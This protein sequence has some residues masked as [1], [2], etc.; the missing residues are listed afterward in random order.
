M[1]TI[2][3]TRAEYKAKYGVDAPGSSPATT[4]SEI[5]ATPS[6]KVVKMSRAE[7]QNKYGVAAPVAPVAPQE[8]SMIGGMVKSLV[9]APATMIARP[10]QAVQSAWQLAGMDIKGNE[11]K[12]KELNDEAYRLAFSLRTAR[13][14]DKP[15]I[16]TRV[17]EIQNQVSEISRKLGEGANWKPSAGGIIAEAPENWGDVKKDVGRGIQTVALGLTAPG[18]ILASGAAFGVGSSLEQGND[19]FSWD[20]AAS[21]L[22][23]MGFAKSID[24]WGKPVI[25]YVGGKLAGFAP[26][27]LKEIAAKGEGAVLDFMAKNKLLGGVAAPLSEKITAGAQA[28]D[29][30]INKG[31]SSMWQGAKNIR[32]S[33]YPNLS[34]K[35]R[36]QH[37]EQTETDKLIAP[38]R[39]NHKSF[40]SSTD[41]LNESKRRGIDLEQRV[42]DTKIYDDVVIDD[43][44][45]FDTL[46]AQA[47]LLD[48]TLSHIDK[49]LMHVFEAVEP[50][51]PLVRSNEVLQA[52]LN[53]ANSSDMLPEDKANFIKKL[54]LRYGPDSAEAAAYRQG[55]KLRDL[56]KS[57]TARTKGVYKKP[58]AGGET[59]ISD[60][61]SI[62]EKELESKAFND[63]L[64]QRTPEG[65]RLDDYFKAQESN[66]Q[67][68]EYLKTLHSKMAPKGKFAKAMGIAGQV[69]GGLLGLKMGGPF[70]F[71]PGKQFGGILGNTIMNLPNP[72]KVA[73]LKRI[74]VK[75]P[76]I[77][78]AIEKFTKE[79]QEAAS[80]RLQIGAGPSAAEKIKTTGVNTLTPNPEPIPLQYPY[81]ETTSGERI[82]ND[83]TQNSRR[84][85]NTPQLP[86]G[87]N[88]IR[89][90][91]EGTPNVVGAPYGAGGNQGP[92]GG[93]SQRVSDAY[94]RSV[95]EWKA[96]GTKQTYDNWVNKNTPLF[97]G[98]TPK[99]GAVVAKSSSVS[100]EIDQLQTEIEMLEDA[101]QNSRVNPR[102]EK[103]ILTKKGTRK[104]NPLS[105]LYDRKEGGLRELGDIRN[106]KVSQQFEDQMK[107]AGYTEPLEYIKAVNQWNE[108]KARLKGMK[109]FLAQVKRNPN[110][111]EEAPAPIV[112]PDVEIRPEDIPF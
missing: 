100:N 38:G 50:G 19:L 86:A 29:T 63:L 12:A 43:T 49:E 34:D 92:V 5:P 90:P 33:Q 61:L 23:S 64:R 98:S 25:N 80:S 8:G 79:M 24:K 36:E 69:T 39:D 47:G 107:A 85:F 30:G 57:K 15:A 6:G 75:T 106:G 62:Q 91:S 81:R 42:K 104:V 22:L 72:L 21:T 37:F 87:N 54:W 84:L 95:M 88:A 18:T 109:S 71:F 97:S 70:G 112:S 89:M 56:Y 28:F 7:Y 83:Y 103:V 82:V 9:T 1:A 46:D 41:V 11:A 45:H 2:Q 110:I 20:T 32:D 31:A 60:K 35:A 105:A 73:A 10:F 27:A 17:Q 101:I 26:T 76:E 74:P 93:M 99:K 4:T 65:A 51:V 78:A 77:Y 68:V 13:E 48:D 111:L 58:K 67:L 102:S 53:R 55:Y 3:M 14:E 40:K 96:S 108:Q 66:Y 59:T 44:G 52:Q 16:K 94:N